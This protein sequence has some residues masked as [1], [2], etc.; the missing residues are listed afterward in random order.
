MKITAISDIHGYLPDIPNCDLLLIAGD[1]CPATDHSFYFQSQWLKADFCNWLNKVPAK[2]IIVVAGNHDWY[3]SNCSHK[4]SAQF[5]Q[6]PKH[7][8][9][10]QDS[11]VNI[12]GLN[13]Y[14]TP[15]Q[16]I[17]CDWAFNLNEIDL[18]SKFKAI[19]DNCDVLVTHGPPYGYCDISDF[20][21]G[22]HLG[23]KSLLK[24]IMRVLPKLVVFGHIHTGS[25]DPIQV[26][27]TKQCNIVNVSY[28]NERYK[29]AYPPFT[30]DL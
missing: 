1:I 23:S 26:G 10:L 24:H 28:V 18:D 17:F 8:H 13:I 29:P 16:P 25:H 3:F 27:N 6:F 15:W 22:Q 9:Y 11:T 5:V 21:P 20:Q 7:V 4:F 14:G 12:D 2:N 30:I 19:P